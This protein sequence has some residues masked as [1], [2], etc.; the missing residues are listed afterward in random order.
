MSNGFRLSERSLQNLQGVK[1]I[2]ILICQ[3]AI[4]ITSI[5]FGVTEGLRSIERQRQLMQ[6]GVSQTLHSKHLDGRAIDIIA[7][8]PDGAT[9]EPKFYDDVADAFAE[10]ARDFKTSIRWGGAWHYSNIANYSGPMSQLTNDYVNLRTE[11]GRVPFLD[12]PHFELS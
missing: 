6:E 3:R 11:E 10:A 1:P 9:W 2:L 12:Y 5:D 7:Y 8:G 4:E